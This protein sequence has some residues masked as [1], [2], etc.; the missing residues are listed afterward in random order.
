M[1]FFLLIL[2][3]YCG[4]NFYIFT[5]TYQSLEI[6]PHFRWLML[7]LMVLLAISFMVMM[8]FKSS[9]DSAGLNI[10]W[11]VSSYWVV[12]F[13]YLLLFLLS[14]DILRII[15]WAFGVHPAT[16][17]GLHYPAMKL[18]L[19]VLTALVFGVV[20]GIGTYRAAHPVVNTVELTVHKEAP[21]RSELNIVLLSDLHLGSINGRSALER[22]VG[23]VNRLQPDIVLI[24]GDAFDD[25]PAPVERKHLGDILQTMKAPLGVYFS[26]GNHD[27]YGD[28]ARAVQYLQAHGVTTLQDSAVLIDS[29][30]YVVGRLDKS[31]T[32]GAFANGSRKTV[33]ELMKGLDKSK[34]I[35]LMDHQPYNLELAEVAGVDLQVSGHTHHGQLWPFSII[36]E[37][38]YEIDHGYLRKGDSHFYVSQ[39]VGTWGPPLRIGTRGEIVLLKVRFEQK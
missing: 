28:F 7:A 32:P 37:R 36:T 11:Q 14:I 4:L 15:C 31:P 16:F 24:A 10:L 1:L 33:E 25:N 26:Q 35:I 5:R 13:L 39:G 3:A 17:F 30:F 19:F 9:H 12:V 27:G 18:F 8:F 38:M 29:S 2:T 6:V 20:L 22:W 23:Q 21:G 34:P